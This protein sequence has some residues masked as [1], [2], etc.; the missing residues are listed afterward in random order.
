[1]KWRQ[2]AGKDFSTYTQPVSGVNDTIHSLRTYKEVQYS[3]YKMNAHPDHVMVNYGGVCQGKPHQ[4]S[5]G[6]SS[7]FAS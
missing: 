1:M 6:L 2:T 3:K 7:T 4:V 5:T